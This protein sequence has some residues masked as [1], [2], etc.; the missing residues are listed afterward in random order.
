MNRIPHSIIELVYSAFRN[1]SWERVE[2]LF[3]ATEV[4][5]FKWSGSI[6][7]NS[8]LLNTLHGINKKCDDP[9]EML[10]RLLEGYMDSSSEDGS[11]HQ[12]NQVRIRQ[13]LA[14]HGLQYISGGYISAGLVAPASLSL[15][16]RVE[17]EGLLTIRREIDRAIENVEKDPQTALISANSA[18][19]ATFKIYLQ[20]RNIRYEEKENAVSLWNKVAADIGIHPKNMESK[21]MKKVGSGLFQIVEGVMLSRSKEFPPHGK[22]EELPAI[23]PPLARLA[24]HAAHTLCVYVLEAKER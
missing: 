14:N 18:M 15:Q 4:P 20:C 7:H 8:L 3:N 11:V 21:E 6:S 17:K 23:T 12:K 22:T 13:A 5:P 1:F 16:E 9:L 10:G 24:I 2:A 19:E